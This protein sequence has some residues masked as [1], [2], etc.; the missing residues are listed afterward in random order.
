[1]EYFIQIHSHKTK[2][3]LSLI[4]AI[5]YQMGSSLVTT[6]GSF[7]VYFISYI[8]YKDKNSNINLQ[9]GN[10]NG[11]IILLLLSSFSPLS[12]VI[13]KQLGSILTLILSS[14]IVIFKE[15]YGYFILYQY[16]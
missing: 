13:D 5:L 3:I 9:F 11:P 1:M 15:I 14:S 10:L 8:Y 2:F 16:L 7:C 6:I 12:G 4:S